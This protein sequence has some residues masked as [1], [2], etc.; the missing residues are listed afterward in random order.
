MNVR[1]IMIFI[2]KNK[3]WKSKKHLKLYFKKQNSLNNKYILWKIKL[4]NSLILI[5]K[6]YLNSKK[7]KYIY[8]YII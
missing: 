3:K 2:W 7:K 6:N 1:R 4:N 8:I 5:N